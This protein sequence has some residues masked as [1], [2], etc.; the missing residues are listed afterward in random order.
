MDNK[1][2]LKLFREVCDL[3]KNELISLINRA[4]TEHGFTLTDENDKERFFALLDSFIDERNA[5]GY[6]IFLNQLK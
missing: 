6:E 2:V 4:V 5:V 3:N 1:N